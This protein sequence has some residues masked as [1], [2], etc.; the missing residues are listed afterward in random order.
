VSRRRIVLTMV[1][2]ALALAG[3][4]GD[5]AAQAGVAYSVPP[6]NPFVG[7]AGARPEIYSHGLRNPWRFSFDR[8][9]G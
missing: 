5:A 9:T 7:Q 4:A 3:Q 1:G 8:D 2:C 6:D